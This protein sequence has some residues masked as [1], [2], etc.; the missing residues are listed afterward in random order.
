MVRA[1]RASDG[2][3]VPRE[4]FDRLFVAVKEFLMDI[5]GYLR[6]HNVAVDRLSSEAD[7]F[8]FNCMSWL[9]VPQVLLLEYSGVSLRLAPDQLE[10]VWRNIF[11]VH[12]LDESLLTQSP[13]EGR[14]AA[15]QQQAHETFKEYVVGE[16]VSSLLKEDPLDMMAA[17]MLHCA[18][19][20]HHLNLVNV[21]PFPW[22]G[23]SVPD[24][25]IGGS[26]PANRPPLVAL[27][28]A[29]AKKDHVRVLRVHAVTD[30]ALLDDLLVLLA[31]FPG[32][33]RLELVACSPPL[34][35]LSLDA[36]RRAAASPSLA[37]AVLSSLP[38]ASLS[39]D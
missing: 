7:Q 1:A 17:L 29:V 3:G 15:Q 21:R 35:P 4:T 28:D 20:I 38:A 39:D 33:R 27:R 30:A 25:T 11:L 37:I 31:A 22:V 34:S 13:S 10:H 6:Q 5:D 24:I 2:V 26:D 32:L 16:H 19:R 12:G 9:D 36:L 23:A 8:F 18:R 14:R